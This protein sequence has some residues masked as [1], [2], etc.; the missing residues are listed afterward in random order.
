VS[1]TDRAGARC[2]KGWCLRIVQDEEVAMELRDARVETAIAVSDLDRARRFYEDQLGLGPAEAQPGGVRY[3][4]GD[5]TA[6]FVY[7]SAHAGSTSAT[8][9]G[10]AVDDL[11]QTMAD[12][13]SRGAEFE[14]YDQPD[15]KTDE[16]GVFEAGAIKAA[17]VRDPDGN[18]LALTQA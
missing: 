15:I 6:I 10:W 11:D 2:L 7:T 3:P 5:G 4:C 14:H 13:A 16:R 18:T 1:G 9:A 12:L 17:W 8:V